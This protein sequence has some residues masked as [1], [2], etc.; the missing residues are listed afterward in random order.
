MDR[1]TAIATFEEVVDEGCECPVCGEARIDYLEWQPE[2][3][4]YGPE[5]RCTTCD[6]HYSLSR[7]LEALCSQ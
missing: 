5:I 4:Y 1:L 7:E 6:H 3:E 2:E